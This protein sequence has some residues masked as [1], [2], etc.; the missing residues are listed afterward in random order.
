VAAGIREARQE[1]QRIKEQLRAMG[2][3]VEDHLDDETA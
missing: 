1:I 3:P 2:Q